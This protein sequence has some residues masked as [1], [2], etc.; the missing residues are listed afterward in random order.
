MSS[1]SE[2]S[3]CQANGGKNSSQEKI[4]NLI[5]IEQNNQNKITWDQQVQNLPYGGQRFRGNGPHHISHISH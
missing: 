2:K 4:K 1:C 5:D 3:K